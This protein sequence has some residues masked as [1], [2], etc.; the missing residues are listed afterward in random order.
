MNDKRALYCAWEEVT[1]AS[2][3]YLIS[4]VELTSFGYASMALD[5]AASAFD[6]KLTKLVI[7]A[8]AF[9]RTWEKSYNH[10]IETSKDS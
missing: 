4:K 3:H 2:Q 9:E 10:G 6:H 5:N 1:V 7:S 8:I